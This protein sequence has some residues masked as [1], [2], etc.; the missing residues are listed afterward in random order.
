M[1]GLYGWLVALSSTLLCSSFPLTQS[2]LLVIKDLRVLVVVYRG[3][4]NAPNYLG[5]HEYQ[6]IV[7]PWSVGVFSI[8]A[9]RAGA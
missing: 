7:R 6:S 2:R 4:T 8:F 3:E 1:R 9:T 5:E